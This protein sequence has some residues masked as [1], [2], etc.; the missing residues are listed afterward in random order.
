M[1]CE[2]LVLHGFCVM[3]GYFEGLGFVIH[4]H[5]NPADA[6]LDIISG[7]IPTAAGQTLNMPASW[8]S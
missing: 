6:Y 3:Q 2:Y 4:E 7:G 8:R 1:V 5:M